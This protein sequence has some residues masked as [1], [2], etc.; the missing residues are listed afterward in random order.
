[1]SVIHHATPKMTNCIKFIEQ[2][3]NIKY[4]GLS[5]R[6]ANKFISDNLNKSKQAAK[7]YKQRNKEI[8][9]Q[10]NIEESSMFKGLVPAD[11]DMI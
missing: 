5:F 3:L 9:S 10:I 7:I 8:W 4:T 6:E 2:N 1:M 11:I